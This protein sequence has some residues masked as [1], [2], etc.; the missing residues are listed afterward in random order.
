MKAALISYK[1][2]MRH[3]SKITRVCVVFTDGNAHDEIDLKKASRAWFDHNVA[4]FAVGIGDHFADCYEGDGASY[5]G[6]KTKTNRGRICQK[7]ASQSPHKHDPTPEKYPNS[8]LTSNYCRNPDGEPNGPWCYTT[9][10]K[11]RWE[12]CGIP[13]CSFGGLEKITLFKERTMTVA[14][15]KSIGG[16]AKSLA[17][18]LC[19]AIPKDIDDCAQNPCG[20]HG[21]CLD[22]LN[23]FTCACDYG[24]KGKK[25]DQSIYHGCTSCSNAW[26][27]HPCGGGYRYGCHKGKCW[28]SCSFGC[29]WCWTR[30]H[31]KY[32][33][34]RC[35]TDEDCTRQ[36]VYDGK[37]WGAC[38]VG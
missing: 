12:Y 14:N 7:W 13:K 30:P 9:D 22:K 17:K 35:T 32:Q 19:E 28:S 20:K 1:S 21:I 10:S 34:H 3:D 27:K 29:Q 38:T 23:D 26:S 18:S 8:D 37:C 5:R 6:R 15:F 31:G 36:K 16:K 11:K 24:W 25:C 2:K 4:V 33:H